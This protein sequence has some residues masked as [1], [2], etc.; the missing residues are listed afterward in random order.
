MAQAAAT[1]TG[2]HAALLPQSPGG[3]GPG[4]VLAVLVHLGLALALTTA[5]DWRARTPEVVTAE[6]WSAVPE[7]APPPPPFVAPVLP[8]P[9]PEVRTAPPPA[10]EPDIAV[11]QERRRKVEA[12]K[13]K[14]QA[15]AE[16]ERR[17]IDDERRK[18]EDERKAADE[19]RKV[20]ED[21]KRLAD[22]RRK[23]DEERQQREQELREAKAE[24]ERLARQREAN[25]RRM[26]GQVAD[27]A[28]APVGNGT[29]T[30]NAAP[31]AQ[32]RGKL[33]AIVRGNLV[34]TGNLPG[35]PVATVE[36]TA[37]AG[38]SIISRRLAKSS[39][40]TAWD[41]AV[42]RALDRTATLPR[43]SDGRV[44]PQVTFDFR[45]AD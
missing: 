3:N 36:V 14:A 6:L 1:L 18:A 44:P 25:L 4:A 41:D 28:S 16:A 2:R 5:V 11:E 27:A 19:R 31:S 8:P 22:K 10:P 43:D 45:Y 20:E 37:A 33:I 35:N 30:R 17:R 9:A 34:F 40:V 32:Y 7:S 29:G 21:K 23:A 39:G 12:E 13:L 15:Q 24:D 26:M 42:I 38:G